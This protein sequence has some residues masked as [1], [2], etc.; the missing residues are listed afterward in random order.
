MADVYV[1]SGATG[2]ND[3]TSTTDAY[4]DIL[5]A[6]GATA[7]DVVHVRGTQVLTTPVNPTGVG[8]ATNF[9]VWEGVNDSWVADG[10]RAILDGNSAA[11]NGFGM[12]GADDYIVWRNFE[13]KNTT[14]HGM[15][16]GGQ[17][18]QVINCY[19]HNCGGAGFSGSDGYFISCRSAS[20]TSHGYANAAGGARYVNCQADNNT[21]EGFEGTGVSRT[22]IN[23][24]AYDNSVDGGRFST[25]CLVYGFTAHGNTGDGIEFIGSQTMGIGLRCTENGGYG[26]RFLSPSWD[27][28]GATYIPNTSEDLD[29]TTGT[30]LNTFQDLDDTGKYANDLVGTDTDG[31]YNNSAGD[32]YTLD[33]AATG[34]GIEVDYDGTNKTFV[35]SSG[36]APDPSAGGGGGSL[37]GGSLIQ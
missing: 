21:G 25:D 4:T 31:G 29:N 11:S 18:N 7:G 15:S 16:I 2:A 17:E 6:I 30:T 26:I 12:S 22:F 33:S 13:I 28:I 23:C 32:D 14:S 9:I 24:L 8:T 37:I 1:W 27:T 5:S 34:Y 19:A 20:N 10:T 35:S 36:L 3:G